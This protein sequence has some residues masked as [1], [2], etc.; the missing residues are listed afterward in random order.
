MMR[1]FLLLAL[2]ASI[3]FA[4]GRGEGKPSSLAKIVRQMDKDGVDTLKFN[5]ESMIIIVKKVNLDSSAVENYARGLDKDSTKNDGGSR[6]VDIPPIDPSLVKRSNSRQ[7]IVI[8][9]IEAS[10]AKKGKEIVI[11][12]I[13]K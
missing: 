11:P 1:L 7:E 12:P 10:Q 5:N 2:F 4:G 6:L 9:P 13:T 8:P 3:S